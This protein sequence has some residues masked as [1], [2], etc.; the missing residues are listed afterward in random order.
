MELINK[1]ILKNK[2]VIPVS[3]ELRIFL[4]EELMY[5]KDEDELIYEEDIDRL[6]EYIKEVN[7]I[8]TNKIVI[9]CEIA[10]EFIELVKEKIKKKNV[11]YFTI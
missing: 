7:E 9:P 4:I 10:V 3:E 2:K 11:L 6:I 8:R 1:E 5:R